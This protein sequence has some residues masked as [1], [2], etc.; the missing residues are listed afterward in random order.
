MIEMEEFVSLTMAAMETIAA[1]SKYGSS[2]KHKTYRYKIP[3]KTLSCL[4]NYYARKMLH[5]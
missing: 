2:K 3:V 1:K 4:D 5:P